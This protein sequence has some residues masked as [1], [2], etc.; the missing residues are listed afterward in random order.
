MFGPLKTMLRRYRQDTSGATLMAFALTVP[1]V[2]GAMGVS[3]DIARS[4]LAKERL[5]HALDAAALAGAGSPGLSQDDLHQ[6]VQ[7]FFDRNYGS[8]NGINLVIDSN[9]PTLKVSAAVQVDATFMRVLGVSEVDINSSAVVRREVRG[10]EVAMVLDVTGSMSNNNNIG[11]LRTAATNFTNILCPG[12]SCAS[13]VKIGL[14]P[15]STSVNVGPYGLGRTPSGAVYDTAFVNN[16]QNLLWRQ[17]GAGST[18][19][20]WGC[21]LEQAPPRDT[22]NSEASWRWDMYRFVANNGNT[23]SPNTDCNKA[24][25]LPLTTSK[26]TITSRISGFT[27]SGRTLSN[28]GMVWGYRLL[29]P[30]FPFREGAPFNDPRMRKVALLMTDGENIIGNAYSA[31]GPYANYSFT[32][33]DLDEKLLTTCNRMKDD[34]IIIY[35]ITFTSSINNTTKEYFRNCATDDTKYYDAPTQDD[36]VNTFQLIAAELSNLYISK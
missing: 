6:R 29:S 7:A 14:V 36:L 9:G 35:T 31:Y 4:F 2:V 5:S 24:Y 20:W 19:A 25:I 10:L 12:T 15:F 22:Q 27:P 30:E 28:I 23:G 13:S 32:N 17:S 1:M 21:V 34:G 11:A 18:T 26:T 16:P 8:S 33:R 3:V